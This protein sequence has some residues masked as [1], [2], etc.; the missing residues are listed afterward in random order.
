MRFPTTLRRFTA[1]SVMCVSAFSLFTV[2]PASAATPNAPSDVTVLF[3]NS[4]AA[5][6]WLAPTPISGVTITGYT[7]TSSPGGLTC[8]VAFP[9]TSC[10]VPGLT[11]S[12]SYT[13]S[14][15]ASSAGGV[16]PSASST[17]STSPSLVTTTTTL[18]A[19]PNG[20]Q[21][22]GTLIV[23]SA[24]VTT[25]A[26]G[27][28]AFMN[29]ST[30]IAGCGTVVVTSGYAECNTSGLTSGTNSLSAVYSGDGNYSSSTSSTLN[31]S[32]SS[33]TLTAG[34]SPLVITTTAAPINTAITLATT[35]GNGSGALTYSVT[36]G[37]ASGC[38]I[39]GATLT[40]QTNVSGTCLVTATQASAG[41]YLGESSNVTTVNFFWQYAGTYEVISY[42]YSYSC[43]TGD[44]LNGI[45]C[46]HS[47]AATV[48]SYSCSVG[49]WNGIECIYTAT[50]NYTC[51]APWSPPSGS[52]TCSRVLTNTFVS[53]ANCRAAG[54]A[55]ESSGS[56]VGY[57]CSGSGSVWYLTGVM[58]A[59]TTY[60]CPSGGYIHGGN[61]VLAGTPNYTCPSGGSYSGSGMCTIVDDY[62]AT[63]TIVSANYGYTCSIAYS[64]LSTSTICSVSGGSGPNLRHSNQKVF[65]QLIVRPHASSTKGAS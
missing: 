7:V 22:V 5:V 31:Y 23:L 40:V 62:Y 14:V 35:D 36:S 28:V 26:T 57:S 21:N 10:T 25:G 41:T 34:T 59:T 61:C 16:G 8:N 33:S 13:F 24:I 56:W 49:T 45:Y 6:S 18:S 52:P 17:A 42:N 30:I 3:T 50:S 27:T 65:A 47:Y 58:S 4:I 11:S 19:W 63:A 44:T 39:S 20:P 12:T 60:T 55:N 54:N 46:N 2:V 43:N 38:S 32:I 9:V 64:S 48:S 37:T 53:L 51:T 29:G 15:V 1:V